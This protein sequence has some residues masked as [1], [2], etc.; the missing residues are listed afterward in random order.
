MSYEG[1]MLGGYLFPEKPYIEIME[2][3]LQ[4]KS[5]LIEIYLR[6]TKMYITYGDIKSAYEQWDLFQTEILQNPTTS[7]LAILNFRSSTN[8]TWTY[9]DNEKNAI[10]DE[11]GKINVKDISTDLKREYFS[12]IFTKHLSKLFREINT[13][14][15]LDEI[16]YL[17]DL[18]RSEIYEQ[19]NPIKYSNKIYLY[20]NAIYGNSFGRFFNGKVADAYLNH[21]GATHFSYL[22][23]FLNSGISTGM[24]HLKDSS[25]KLEERAQ[26]TLNFVKLLIASNNRTPWYTGGDLIVTNKQGQIV[27]NIQLK[28]SGAEGSWIGNIRTK[29]LEKEIDKILETIK[30]DYKK[31][32]KSFYN[33]LKTSSVGEQ[34]GDAIIEQAKKDVIKSLTK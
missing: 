28:T 34:V 31:T 14:M 7:L 23:N 25:V 26:G 5:Q 15:E 19:L 33:S 2:Q 10:S 21:I 12:Q 20:K 18:N 6:K 8:Q 22:N 16:E 3:L 4:E 29:T 1:A 11:S 17:Y 24:E 13:E 30:Q 32:A 27:A 9:I